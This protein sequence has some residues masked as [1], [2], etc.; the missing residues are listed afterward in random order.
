MKGSENR[1]KVA[2]NGIQDKVIDQHYVPRCYM[3]NFANVSGGARKEK[4]LVAFFQYV[5]K[6][7]F[8]ARIVLLT[9]SYHKGKKFGQKY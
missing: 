2:T 6:A 7:I 3:K 4:V 8:M 5:T 1:A 9:K